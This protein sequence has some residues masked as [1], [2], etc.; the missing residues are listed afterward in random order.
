MSS[1]PLQIV[2]L[3]AS[4]VKRL[5]AVTI[6]P[7]G[8]MVV[9]SGANGAG[10]SSVLDAIAMA[11]GGRE[12]I[13]AEPI[14]RG[15][16]HAEV[17]V[18]LGE[19]IVRRTFTPSGGGQLI[20]TNREGARFASPQTMLD[21]LVGRLTFDPLAFSREEPKRQ[22]ETL[23]QL[24]GLDFAALDKERAELYAQRTERNREAKQAAARL[25]GMPRHEGAP[26]EPVSVSDLAA[27]L[28]AANRHNEEVGRVC[29]LAIGNAA[30]LKAQRKRVESLRA[31]LEAAERR[32]AET[33]E[34]D[35]RLQAEMR[36]AKEIDTAPILARMQDA[37]DVNRKV[38]ENHQRQDLAVRV[39][40]LEGA[41]GELTSQIEAIDQQRA[42]AIAK[43]P[44]PVPGLGF[45]AAGIVTL[46]GLPLEQA[47]A[48]ERLRVSVAIGLAM[49]PRLRV[50]LIR[51]ASLLD[52]RSMRMV[53]ELA[54]KAGAQLW[55]ETV[56]QNPL[57]T[58]VI[59][60]GEVAA[61]SPAA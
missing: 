44:M 47:S 12:Q 26:A 13:P 35:V 6:T 8:D 28:Q 10:K 11:L 53:A 61:A 21:A 49:N 46:N 27:E 22:A 60:D 41:A 1:A 33:I 59:E 57:T 37:E 58:V 17:V 39:A 40:E 51:D 20:V 4:N 50:L 7:D 15:A 16:D 48:A 54:S 32:L 14:R 30:D 19:I 34:D 42:D 56:E 25:A 18:D 5:K 29:R 24:L 2:E 3:R 55:V 38:R 45:D 23:R 31:E 9:L 52:Q 36:E 43:A